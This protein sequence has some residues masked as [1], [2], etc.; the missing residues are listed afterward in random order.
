MEEQIGNIISKIKMCGIFNV[1]F[2]KVHI[3]T[4]KIPFHPL[5]LGE[6][7]ALNFAAVLSDFGHF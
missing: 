1:K 6:Q 7:S 5:P 4:S 3:E 2:V